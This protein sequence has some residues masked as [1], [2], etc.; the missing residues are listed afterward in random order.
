MQQ[1]AAGASAVDDAA[2]PATGGGQTVHA[3]VEPTGAAPSLATSESADASGTVMADGGEAAPL[4]HIVEISAQ[5]PSWTQEA[6]E[7]TTWTAVI[8]SSWQV[9][10]EISFNPPAAAAGHV[11][12][13]TVQVVAQSIGPTVEVL[14]TV[15]ETTYSAGASL[16]TWSSSGPAQSA[17]AHGAANSTVHAS[18]QEAVTDAVTSAVSASGATGAQVVQALGG[19]ST[20]V[21]GAGIKIGVLSS[22]F[23]NQGGAAAD[24][25]S[26]ALPSASKIQILK[27]MASGGSDEG[28]AMMQVIHDIAPDASLAFYTASQS[29]QDFANGI[30]ALANAGCKVIV[31][32]VS[33][34]DEPFFQNGIIAQAIQTVQAMGVTYVTSAGNNGSSAYQTA[35]TSMSGSFDGSYYAG[36]AL[37][38]GGN[39]AQTISVTAGA[40]MLVQWDEPFGQ[41][42]VHLSVNVYKDGQE[43]A[44]F[45]NLNQDPFVG[46]QFNVSGTYQIVIANSPVGPT[47]STIKEILAGNGLPVSISGAN[48][49]TVFGHAM[50]PGVITVGAVN[51]A[52]TPAFGATAV[53]ESFS[54]S[55][56]GTEILL[57]NDGTRLTTPLQLNPVVVS[58][59]DNITTTVSGL[60]DFYGTSAAAPTVAAISALILTANP[61]LTS[62]NVSEILQQ[63]SVPMTNA[64]V[65]G[66]GLA[67]LNPAVGA[68]PYFANTVIEALGSI[69]LAQVG[70][71]YD[72]NAIGGSTTVA[73][74]FNGANV[75][76]HQLSNW[77]PI[78]VESNGSGGYEVAWKF[79]GQDLYT[80]WNVDAAGNYTSNAIGGVSGS[81]TSFETFETAFHQDLNGDGTIG[82]AS[83]VIEA[84]GATSLVQSGS[85]YFLNPVTG[86][87]G[88]QVKFNGSTVAPGQLGGWTPIAAEAVGGGYQIAW[89][90]AGSDLY[91]VWNTDSTGNYTS[92]AIGAVSGSSSALELLESNFQQD[93]NGDGTIGIPSTVIESAGSTSLVLAGSSYFLDPVA[94]GTGPQ[95][96]FGGSVVTIGQLGGWN[97]IAAEASGSGYLVAWKMAGSDLYTVWN[98]DSSGNYTSNAIGAVA[99]S[100]ASL[101]ALET[102]FHQDLNGDGTI[103][104][105]SAAPGGSVIEALGSTSLSLSG[106]AYL[107]TPVSGGTAV[108]VMFGGNAVVAGQLGGWTAI[109]AEASGSG[110][111]IAWKMAGSDLYT[112]WNADSSG[113]YTSNAIGAVA[114]SSASLEALETSFHQDLNGDGTIGIP[115][116]V[117]AVTASAMTANTSVGA[118]L[119]L[120]A[121]SFSGN[122]VGFGSTAA[123]IDVK[124]IAFASLQTHFDETSGVLSLSDG[125]NS[126]SF[127]VVGAVAQDSFHFAADGQG[128][129][130]VSGSSGAA[131]VAGTA[132]TSVSLEGHDT[133]VFAAHFGQVNITDFNLGTDKIVFSQSLFADQ[134]ALQ[135]AIHDDAAGNAVIAD[136][137]ADTITIQHV[138]TAEL[139]SHLSSFHLV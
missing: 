81:S 24:E 80:V 123:Q 45:P 55:G 134:A 42:A 67:Q 33:Y 138:S 77:M 76:V 14:S 18:L 5:T 31:D 132:G 51:S 65:A 116:S 113:N 96:K 19:N 61:T 4:A 124:G 20:G 7:A 100:S 136:A 125:T 47:P 49:G 71:I 120:A 23:N 79:Q 69:S 59:V 27:D 34:T 114:G 12:T 102:S 3:S 22:S 21:T 26:G 126:S 119:V 115:A 15:V 28:R 2:K 110:Y 53:S 63:T 88:P 6:A 60:T 68:A 8:G 98:T 104:A 52:N 83:T 58:G 37:S 40:R 127:H 64:A 130:L 89:K 50:T 105:P 82:V 62:A 38:F 85:S 11:T 43:V 112:V 137:A 56:A 131:T 121:S 72:L 86:G 44:S 97:P 91:T 118:D 78:G 129:T 32:D 99:G 29:E 103:G 13:E 36:N 95:I 128:G 90:M 84:I 54:S 135:A 92:N 122:L 10:Q 117:S 75:V 107:M 48:V 66:A 108:Q 1:P 25:A 73:L 133:F 39:I 106:T 46:F 74:R 87:T 9:T 16:Q 41:A 30:I 93:L 101:E 70:V 17:S 94:G 111:Q 57:A 109:G 139:L 35:W